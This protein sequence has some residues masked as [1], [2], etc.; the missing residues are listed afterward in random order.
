M[1]LHGRRFSR[2][3]HVST[4]RCQVAFSRSRAAL[5][6]SAPPIAPQ[7]CFDFF[8]IA[9][10]YVA[11]T[12]RKWERCR[13]ASLRAVPLYMPEPYDL[14]CSDPE[15]IPGLHTIPYWLAGRG[16]LSKRPQRVHEDHTRNTL[17]RIAVE[18]LRMYS[19][20]SS[21]FARVQDVCV[22]T[23][24][25]HPAPLSLFLARAFD[26]LHVMTCASPHQPRK[27]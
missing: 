14:A 8:V 6:A 26:A 17:K 11:L 22:S 4:H 7:S 5:T 20:C 12:K 15:N 19:R 13:L 10:L 21:V 1:F 3:P 27:A 18:F 16:K 24:L 2:C 25:P 9:S 23:C